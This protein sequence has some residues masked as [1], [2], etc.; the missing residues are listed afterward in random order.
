LLLVLCGGLTG[1]VTAEL[2]EEKGFDGFKQAARPPNLQVHKAPGDWLIEYDEASENNERIRR[3]A[4][5]LNQNQ[6]AIAAH[7]KP[8]FVRSPKPASFPVA[9]ALISTNGQQFTVYAGAVDIGTHEFPV[10]PAPSGRVKQILLT[11]LAV[12]VDATI[13]G[14]CVAAIAGYAW[15]QAGAP[16][17]SWD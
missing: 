14:A 2:W 6:A 7:K 10:Y 1:C 3:R 8:R 15:L 13:V 4:Y 12:V 9:Q 5:Y 11:P 17:G 16:T